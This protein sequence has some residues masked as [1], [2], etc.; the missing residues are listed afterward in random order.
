M[1]QVLGF[2]IAIDPPK[3]MSCNAVFTITLQGSSLTAA[4]S[5][6]LRIL[7]NQLTS[8]HDGNYTS[9]K[10]N[11]PLKIREPSSEFPSML[12]HLYGHHILDSSQSKTPV[13]RYEATLLLKSM[14]QQGLTALYLCLPHLV[15]ISLIMQFSFISNLIF[16]AVNVLTTTHFVICPVR[17]AQFFLDSMTETA[18]NQLTYFNFFSIYKL[19][20]K[21]HFVFCRSHNSFVLGHSRP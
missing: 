20:I 5:I 7:R 21:H 12:M 14:L 6:I 2:I 11:F 1:W 18:H 17:Y 19:I 10:E 13:L 8:D 15:S 3:I 16:K 9:N 4:K